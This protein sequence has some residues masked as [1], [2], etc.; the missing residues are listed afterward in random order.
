MFSACFLVGFG[1]FWWWLVGVFDWFVGLV[2]LD[3]A[4]VVTMLVFTFSSHTVVCMQFVCAVYAVCMQFKREAGNIGKSRAES[5]FRMFVCSVCSCFRSS[6]FFWLFPFKGSAYT[7]YKRIRNRSKT[8]L[9]PT[10]VWVYDPPTLFVRRLH[11][12]AHTGKGADVRPIRP[13]MRVWLGLPSGKKAGQWG[14]LVLSVVCGRSLFVRAGPHVRAR[15]L[16][17]GVVFPD[18]DGVLPSNAIRGLGRPWGALVAAFRPA[19][20]RMGCRP[21]RFCGG[22]SVVGTV[23]TVFVVF[24]RNAFFVGDS[25]TNHGF[26]SEILQPGLMRG[27]V[28]VKPFMFTIPSHTVVCM[29]FVCTVYAVCMQF[30][31]EAG[32]IGKSRAESTFRMFVCSVCSCFRSSSFFWLFPFK[33]SAYTAYK[34]IRN[35]SKTRLNPTLVWVY[36]PPTLFVRRLHTSRAYDN[37]ETMGVERKK[38]DPPCRIAMPP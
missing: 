22:R 7:A 16:V 10:L 35:R 29:Q 28:G 21:Y 12:N 4:S 34:R 8:R 17:R 37:T 38:S 18:V 20:S 23:S 5:T 11:T 15:I 27:G 14:F 24:D 25:P 36:G 32:N 2:V 31:R 13:E 19:C 33:G 6:S 9:S 30:K 1:W 3:V 26:S